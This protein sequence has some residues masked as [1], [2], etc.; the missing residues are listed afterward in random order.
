MRETP[1]VT[2]RLSPPAGTMRRLLSRQRLQ[3]IAPAMILTPSRLAVKSAMLTPGLR[4]PASNYGR[5][6]APSVIASLASALEWTVSG[7]E[8]EGRLRGFED[9]GARAPVGKASP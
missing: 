7:G 9:L 3:A 2:R 4:G 1:S 8:M 6:L 5:P